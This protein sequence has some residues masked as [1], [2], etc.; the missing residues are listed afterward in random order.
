MFASLAGKLSSALPGDSH[1]LDS[2]HHSLRSFG[3]Q[4]SSSTT[5]IQ[6][7]ITVEKGAALDLDSLGRDSK[8]MSK[9]L[10]TWGQ[11][12]AADLK[13]VTDR[14]AYMNFVLGA[15]STTLGEKINGA[16]GPMKNLRTIEA[17]VQPRRNLRASLQQQINRIEQDQ[18]RGMEKR[19]AELQQK[20]KDAIAEDQPQEAELALSKRQ[21]IR[22]S[23]TQKWEAIREFGEKLVILAQA[24]TP[25]I[26]ALPK[27]PP[28]VETPYTGTLAT[29]AARAAL[30]RA[31]DNYKT[32]QIDLPIVST[33]SVDL[34][35]SD[36]RSFGISHAKELEAIESQETSTS[37]PSSHGRGSHGTVHGHRQTPTSSSTTPAAAATTTTTQSP[38]PIDPSTLNLSPAPIPNLAP[39]PDSPIAAPIPLDP[40][41]LPTVAETGVP[42]SAGAAGP[43]PASGSLH[44]IHAASHSAGP[45]SGGLPGNEPSIPGYG[46]PSSS[47]NTFESATEEKRRL[48]AYSEA[49]QH[50]ETAEQEKS[51]LEREERERVLASSRAGGSGSGKF[52]NEYD[53]APPPSYED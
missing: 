19:L 47:H 3:Q 13:D 51:R 9:E 39:A 50:H 11:G 53:D 24:A 5:P 21:A 38:P 40:A 44:D 16:R 8:A 52:S 6:R 45:R 36:T 49:A 43:G 4:Y 20:L 12:E 29:G 35:R 14:L 27:F 2:I 23:E 18:P 22:T 41:S 15:L 10:Y 34:S 48:Q 33:A 42:L 17:A 25:V 26:E 28:T 37:T 31:L 32:G 30:Q 1:A 7:I 46:T